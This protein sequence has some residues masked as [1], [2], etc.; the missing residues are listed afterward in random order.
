MSTNIEVNS[1]KKEIVDKYLE[2]FLDE[3]SFLKKT[4]VDLSIKKRMKN[5]LLSDDD[6][7]HK[8]FKDLED[9]WF[10]KKVFSVEFIFWDLADKI[11]DFLKLKKIELQKTK[12]HAE[13]AKLAKEVLWKDIE[14]KDEPLD[15]IV[16]NNSKI[17]YSKNDD[18]ANNSNPDLENDDNQDETTLPTWNS[19]DKKPWDEES[20]DR[21]N[22][23]W[24]WA[25]TAVWVWA[26]WRILQ[27]KLNPS[28]EARL[29]KKLK[30]VDLMNTDE[31]VGRMKSNFNTMSRYM[32]QQANNAKNSSK[33]KQNYSKMAIEYKQVADDFDAKAINAYDAR[34]K[35]WKNMPED[36]LNKIP[37]SVSKKFLSLWDDVFEEIFSNT[38]NLQWAKKTKEIKRILKLQ[39]I[40]APDEVIWM[41][42]HLKSAD[43]MKALW[44]VLWHAKAMKWIVKGL[45]SVLLFDLVF[46]WFDVWMFTEG[47][48]EAEVMAKANKI[49]AK[50]RKN[51]A[52]FEL[53]MWAASIVAE[54]ALICGW[55]GTSIWWPIWTAV[56]AIAGVIIW[57]AIYWIQETVN[58]LYYNK[59]D[60]YSQNTENYIVQDRTAIKQSIIQ[61]FGSDEKDENKK[62]LFR[63]LRCMEINTMEEAWKALIFQEYVVDGNYPLL[64]SR[65]GSG[66]PKVDFIKTLS[67]EEQELFKQEDKEMNLQID[68]RMEYISPYINI[69]NPEK[70]SQ[71]KNMLFSS[72]WVKMVENILIESRLNIEKKSDS[73]LD[74][75]E[76]T[77]LSEYKEIYKQNLQKQNKQIFEILEEYY[78]NDKLAFEEIFFY[79]QQLGNRIQSGEEDS[80]KLTQNLEFIKNFHHYKTMDSSLEDKL[81]FHISEV[82]YA[83]AEAVLTDIK[84]INTYSNVK[85]STELKYYFSTNE[86]IDRKQMQESISDN[87]WQ[88]VIYRIAREFHGYQWNNDEFE[89]MNYFSKSQDDT[90]GLYYDDGRFINDDWW[91][92]DKLEFKDF[93]WKTNDQIMQ[94]LFDPNYV[95][96]LDSDAES[97]DDQLNQEYVSKIQKIVD[98]EIEFRKS[99]NKHKIEKEIFDY[100]SSKSQKITNPWE[101]NLETFATTSSFQEQWYVELP[102]HLVKKAT[103][104][105]IWKV[106]LFMFK[107]ENGNLVATTQWSEINNHL[108]FWK[109]K[110][111]IEYLTKLRESITEEEIQ[112]IADTD[113]S[114]KKLE[115]LR[116]VQWWSFSKRN[117]IDDLDIPVELERLISKKWQE[118]KD[119][120]QS[121]YYTDPITSKYLLQQKSKIYKDYFNNLYK[122]MVF[123][124]LWFTFSNDIDN[125]DYFNQALWM[126]NQPKVSINREEKT[127]SLNK[128][129]LRHRESWKWFDKATQS[130]KYTIEKTY[131]KQIQ[132]YKIHW[133]NTL[134]E[135]LSNNQISNEEIQYY[136]DKILISI[137]ESMFLSYKKE[138]ITW[139][140]LPWSEAYDI[141]MKKNLKSRLDYNLSQ[142]YFTT[143]DISS[144]IK[145]EEIKTTPQE[146][147]ELDPE[148]VSFIS[149][150]QDTLQSILDTKSNVDRWGKRWEINLYVHKDYIS[151][152]SW[153][154]ETKI[155]LTSKRIDWLDINF[156]TE[157]DIIMMANIIN[158]FKWYYKPKYPDAA[159]EYDMWQIQNYEE[160]SIINDITILTK[161]QI[162]E[163]YSALREW[164]NAKKF[165]SYLHN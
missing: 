46:L 135:M 75:K 129:F 162:K 44:N 133:W 109:H 67:Q 136:A 101:F 41:F 114:H 141:N 153:W 40:E 103:M 15:D 80:N 39:N 121:L 115:Q 8:D 165:I 42:R 152:Q 123:M 84:N 125:I 9:L 140:L 98:E 134:L 20:S 105:W 38:K 24:Y 74:W 26:T 53:A 48:N 120:K 60:F 32:E 96:M 22:S 31:S 124:Q 13:L 128:W 7:S 49:R 63:N 150:I 29:T 33:M 132:E 51:K 27:D 81:N 94:K 35:L 69:N 28:V 144:Q 5:I 87:L 76:P 83:Y 143:H 102:Y 43:E 145:Y 1:I 108:N 17:N 163:N 57:W 127:I 66:M 156:K 116:S 6:I 164:D 50:N 25:A 95:H 36:I 21:I 70:Y 93:D 155:D 47:L 45:K 82:N 71:M 56:W 12:T 72:Q 11:I 92:D 97:M 18:S 16:E 54:I 86:F 79:I 131:N 52:Y 10:W 91:I 73:F 160:W 23:I 30:W 78:N 161:N 149:T 55:V 68:A 130:Y 61:V 146:L 4:I 106:G 142:K 62:F 113:E 137:F 126:S 85:N 147:Q 14:T 151:I 110:L 90:K 112:I 19:K 158:W 64:S 111:K 3:L 118:W 157:K 34:A 122:S 58:S 154:K 148:K 104:S 100:V 77:N 89:L 99:T 119:I 65:Y 117:H 2:D 159:F 59:K 107:I 37:N 88:N 139:I 138:N